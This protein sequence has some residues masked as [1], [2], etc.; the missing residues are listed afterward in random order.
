MNP[1]TRIGPYRISALIGAGGMGE[2]YRAHDTQLGRDVAIK[3]LPRELCNNPD[4]IARFEREARLL[5]ALN[6]PHIASIHGYEHVEGSAALVLELVEGPTLADRIAS[7]ALPL[8]DAIPIATQIAEALAAAH[9]KGIIHRDLKPANIKIRADGHVKLLDFG[10]ARMISEELTPELASSPTATDH[11]TR[12][13]QVL[14][15]A[16]YMSPEQARGQATDR[17]TDVWAFG[18][19]L[20][21]MLTGRSPFGKATSSDTIA[22]VLGQAP[23]WNALPPATPVSICVLLRQC[24]EKDVRRRRRDIADIALDLQPGTASEA[25]VDQ[26]GDSR[27]HSGT[28]HA[29]LRYAAAA[30]LV[31]AL[32]VSVWAWSGRR[33]NGM[34]PGEVVEFSVYPP[35]GT[36]FPIE[37]GAPWP[38]L[39]PD[40]RQL[41]FV[42]MTSH[43]VAQLWLRQIDSAA[44]QALAG[45]EG[46]AR[47][48]WSPD[49]RSLGFFAD[50]KIKRIEIANGTTQIVCDSPYLGGMS[51]TWG[52][53][54]VI[55]FNHVGGLFRVS[56]MGGRPHLAL[57]EPTTPGDRLQ[58]HTPSFLPDGR[59]FV[60]VTGRA[61]QEDS[62]I[63]IGSL[64]S[65]DSRCIMKV[66]SPARYAAP[67][68]LLFGRDRV[69]RLQRFDAESAELSGEAVPVSTREVRVTPVYRPPPFSIAANVLAFHPGIPRMDLVWRNRTG[70]AVSRL[71][72]VGDS[73]HANF[74]ASQSGRLV[75]TSLGDARADHARTWLYDEQRGS[76]MRVTFDAGVTSAP[77]FSPDGSRFVFTATHAGRAGFYLKTTSGAGGEQ[78]LETFGQEGT[79]SPLDWSADG[80]LILYTSSSPKTSWD[81]GVVPADGRGHAKLI[82]N[83]EHGE[84]DGKFS[85]D[86]K[87]IAYDSTESGRR[88]VWIQPYPPTG[89]RWQVSNAGGVTPQ[90]RQDGKE[91]FYVRGDGTLMAVPISGGA[92]P[93]IGTA[94][95]LFQTFLLGGGT[96]YSVSPDGQRFLM[97][98]APSG[99]DV[100]PITVRTNWRT[101]F[102]QR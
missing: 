81:I 35:P 47:P 46:A 44:P 33:P 96:G 68:F 20:F 11:R 25:A 101:A 66:P 61:K 89:D 31:T 19:V 4:R 51:A 16:A 91:L 2:V 49:S 76:W 62:E 40:G 74:S 78:L 67:G 52:A 83:S 1:S 34:P 55:V 39:S 77:R 99:L 70:A 58:R 22:A 73:D 95:A 97:G 37:V 17:R 64:E 21:E 87:W 6:H 32:F 82:I 14:G 59:H 88:E 26:N 7:G 98:V 28:Q 15:T 79:I 3:V 60:F 18:C 9:E 72:V 100:A 75:V 43:G 29:F 84:R 94:T 13:G 24:L 8:D 48:F 65:Q 57:P 42:A 63:C 36:I 85:P 86:T 30:A 10:L 45:T 27:P 5:A 90:W 23:D 41:A 38:S 54:N 50:G 12:H 102:E 53:D 56:A 93:A 92:A 71:P 69:L 80:Q